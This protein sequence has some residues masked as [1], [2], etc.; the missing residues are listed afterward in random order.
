ML[1]S[2][3]VTR[4]GANAVVGV[5]LPSLLGEGPG[6]RP[7]PVGYETNSRMTVFNSKSRHSR[8]YLTSKTR[9]VSTQ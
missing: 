7:E 2:P 4:Q 5:M 1:S 6:M 3:K 9:L 8:I